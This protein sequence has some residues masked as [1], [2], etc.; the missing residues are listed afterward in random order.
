MYA[1]NTSDNFGSSR[2][3]RTISALPIRMMTQSVIAETVAKRSA[4]PVRQPS[5]KKSA[6]PCS[7][8]TA[9]LPCSDMTNTLTLPS[10]IALREDNPPAP[11]GLPSS[12]AS[13]AGLFIYPG[14]KLTFHEIV[15]MSFGGLRA[16]L[17]R[18]VP[19]PFIFIFLMSGFIAKRTK[20]HAGP[21]P[22]KKNANEGFLL[23]ISSS[24]RPFL[25]VTLG[26]SHILLEM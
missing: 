17:R 16:L 6:L 2:S 25:A 5:P 20:C 14:T 15:C 11:L 7:A 19:S 9:S 26:D 10:R 23:P 4:C 18:L 13:I 22:H 24:D 21:F 3:V 1:K 8:T 12:P